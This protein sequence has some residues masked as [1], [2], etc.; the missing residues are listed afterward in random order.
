MNDI[1]TEMTN[2]L[3]QIIKNQTDQ[4]ERLREA[5]TAM[6][7]NGAKQNW[8]ERYEADMAKARTALS[9]LHTPEGTTD[10]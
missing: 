10:D 5:L 2:E 4:I 1:E 7:R 9:L 8:D 3:L 6:V